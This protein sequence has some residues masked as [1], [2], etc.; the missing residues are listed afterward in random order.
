MNL[1]K[2]YDIHAYTI[3]I[4]KI[5]GFEEMQSMDIVFL[6]EI[7]EKHPKCI[8]GINNIKNNTKLGYLVD[9]EIE[10][11]NILQVLKSLWD[12]IKNTDLENHFEETL[13]DIGPTCIQGISHRIIMDWIAICSP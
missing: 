6:D 8:V 13:I 9:P 7:L 4:K 11:V 5:K 10:G 2:G 12:K 1:Y 3:D